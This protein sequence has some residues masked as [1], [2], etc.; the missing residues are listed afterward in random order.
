M[1]IRFGQ[2]PELEALFVL[3]PD[4]VLINW[5]DGLFQ[6]AT[7]GGL[8]WCEASFSK[9]SSEYRVINDL[10]SAWRRQR[11]GNFYMSVRK[12]RRD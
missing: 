4:A 2:E 12:P 1:D 9:E 11:R 5:K 10:L 6:L 8:L 7:E 3:F